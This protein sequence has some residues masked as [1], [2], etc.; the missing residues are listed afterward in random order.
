MAYYNRVK[1][2]STTNGAGSFGVG[3]PFPGFRTPAQAGIPDAMQVS[4]IAVASDLS[5]WEAGR[6]TYDGTNHVVLRDPAPDNNLGSGAPI[7]FTAPPVVAL[8][9]VAQD[10][11][12]L[13]VLQTITSATYTASAADIGSYRRF[14][15]ASGVAIDVPAGFAQVGAVL[16]YEQSGTGGLTI[17]ADVNVALLPSSPVITAAQYAIVTLIQVAN[18]LWNVKVV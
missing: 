2:L 16:Q 10:L 13:Q 11:G 12:I 18:N 6:N 15:R 5:Q 8:Q 17:S 14:N 4:Y 1:F 7:N 3:S 9:L